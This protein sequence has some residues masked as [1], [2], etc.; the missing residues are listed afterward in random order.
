MTTDNLA[1]KPCPFCGGKASANGKTSYAIPRTK[2][3]ADAWWEDGSPV[4]T[5]YFCSCTQCG[6]NNGGI[7][8]GF[9][10]Q[11]KAIAHWNRRSALSPPSSKEVPN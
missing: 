10:T 11:E 2:G 7:M 9:Q 1:L 6:A 3:T 5:A 4:N 8:G